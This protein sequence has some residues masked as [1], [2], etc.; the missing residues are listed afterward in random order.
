MRF[1]R[2]VGLVGLAGGVAFYVLSAQS[3]ASGYDAHWYH[4]VDKRSVW[5]P[6]LDARLKEV[7]AR[8]AG[9]IGVY[10]QDLASGEAYAWRADQPW[11]LASLIKV[12]VAAEVL[13][14]GVPTQERLTLAESD[15][16]DG[17]GPTNWHDP[18]TPISVGYLL[19]HM[20]TVSDNTATDMLIDRVGLS[21]VNQRAQAMVAANGGDPDAL[22]PISRLV[23]VR[24][25]V[26]GQLHPD[27]RSLGGMDFIALRQSPVS[28]RPQALAKRLDVSLQRLDQPDYHHAFDAYHATGENT[29]TL[30]A[31]GDILATLYLGAI[32]DIQGAPRDELLTL[33]ANTTSGE[34]R[35][36]QG[37]GD[38]INFAH[39]TGTQDRRSCDAGLAEH[40]AMPDTAWAVV[41]CTQGPDAVSQHEQALAEVGQ[42]LRRSGALGMPR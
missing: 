8:F 7:E 38:Q 22:G 39:K 27:A 16:V 42:A 2:L 17:A 1:V 40:D 12:P 28:Q 10:V 19:E 18:G 9:N 31:F 30:K 20:I 26:Y 14:K 6:D 23:E 41:V 29:G 24:Q 4:E 3:A 15:Y 21:N 33:M 37:L 35:L 34:K 5:Q 32:P 13:G 11:Y 36:K 25:G